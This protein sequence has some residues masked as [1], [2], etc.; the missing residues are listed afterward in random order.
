MMNTFYGSIHLQGVEKLHPA[1]NEFF[2]AKRR[3]RGS[4]M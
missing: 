1:S 3:L 4:K 2:A